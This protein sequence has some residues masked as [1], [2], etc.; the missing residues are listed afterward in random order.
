LGVPDDLHV[1]L[2]E[3]LTNTPVFPSSDFDFSFATPASYTAAVTEAQSFYAEGNT[4]ATDIASLPSNDYA[5]IALDNA[6][7]SFDQWVLP[8]QILTIGALVAGF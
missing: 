4:L 7:S 5:Q 2:A 6:L 8:D 3:A 1:G